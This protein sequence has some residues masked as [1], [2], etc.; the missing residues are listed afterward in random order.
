VDV[1]DPLPE[2]LRD[3][4]FPAAVRG[5]DRHS[6]DAYVEHINRVIAELQVSGS[7]A[8]AVRQAL[9]RV[10]EQTSG[11]LRRARETAEEIT[12]TAGEEAEDTT[13]RAKADA[14]DILATA[15]SEA[16]GILARAND[17]AE[18]AVAAAGVDA[19]A[20]R[21][22]ADAA[23]A[24]ERAEAEAQ[25]RSLQT[26]IAAV[27]DERRAVL[28]EARRIAARLEAAV[29][30]AAHGEPAAEPVDESPSAAA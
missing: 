18:Q 8:A 21:R 17:E 19:D 6:V 23:I 14:E 16:E 2:E 22:D 30:E 7:P 27:A 20:R 15:R 4:S 28:D 1:R 10:G 25:M 26:E 3:P 13:A 29:A 9:D 12:R 11:I 5:Y 24:A